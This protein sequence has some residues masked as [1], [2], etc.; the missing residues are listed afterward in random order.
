MSSRNRQ[1]SRQ[2]F[3]E[4]WNERNDKA[5]GAMMT[6]EAVGHSEAGE[7][8]GLNEFLAFR[9][10]FLDAFPDLK[11]EVES[12]VADGDEAAVRWVA[13]G[14]H[15]GDALGVPPCHKAVQIRGISW[16]LFVEDGRMIEGW[17]AWNMGTLMQHLAEGPDEDAAA[18]EDGPRPHT[19]RI[20]PGDPLPPNV[21]RR[22]A[23][24]ARI[25]EVRTEVFG[26]RGGPEVARRLKVPVRTWYNY[27]GGAAVPA[28]VLH[29]FAELTGA[30]LRWLLTGEGPR[31]QEGR[32]PGAGS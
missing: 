14:T 9:N 4:V 21:V 17:D 3:E 23:T 6:P 1:T 31:Y 27:E 13:R 18:E 10:R 7:M 22:R 26:E 30:N 15:S 2:W 29:D 32:E 20:H 28:E 8:V 25:V 16:L 19:R 5:A 12:V 24:A 11:F